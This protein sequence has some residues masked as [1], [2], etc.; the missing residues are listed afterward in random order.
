M[1]VCHP[2]KKRT[3]HTTVAGVP[4][5][6]VSERD[7]IALMCEDCESFKTGQLTTPVTVFDCNGQALSLYA[8]D[9]EYAAHTDMADLVHADGQFIVWMSKLSG[10]GK[11]PE[12]TA[13]TDMIHAAGS[14]AAV[15][16]YRFFLLGGPE[17]INSACADKLCTLYPGL[18]IA[19]R[20]NGYFTDQDE[21]AIVDE[22][23]ASGADIL[24]VGLGKPK[25]M[26]FAHRNK[27]KLKCA[28]IITCGGCFH[29]VVGDYARAPAWM[30]R[31]GLEWLHRMATGPRHLISRY[32]ITIPHAISLVLYKDV[33]GRIFQKKSSS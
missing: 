21:Q 6:L 14:V 19:G 8:T 24:W 26:A 4:V 1:Q 31:A 7:L 27:S 23:N 9:P 15:N 2:P 16:G 13:T 30:Q 5:A 17:K 18:Q 25:E 20:R 29:Y 28:W 22:I 11:V 10:R 3:S 33:L 32:L 12:R